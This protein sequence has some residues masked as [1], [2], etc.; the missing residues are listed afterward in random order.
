MKKLIDIDTLNDAYLD[1]YK[2]HDLFNRYAGNKKYKEDGYRYVDGNCLQRRITFR[3]FLD[4]NGK[5]YHFKKFAKKFEKI[6]NG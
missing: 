4:D 3:E 6:Y 2:L 1:Y 5:S